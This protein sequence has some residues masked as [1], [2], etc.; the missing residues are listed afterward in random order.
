MD[1]GGLPRP[2]GI[3]S[4]VQ[5]AVIT[6]RS[7]PTFTAFS[8]PHQTGRSVSW[9]TSLTTK[10]FPYF[11]F[12]RRFGSSGDARAVRIL[13]DPTASSL[14]LLPLV[15]PAALDVARS[16]CDPAL[17]EYF[18]SAVTCRVRRRLSSAHLL[19]AKQSGFYQS[20]PECRVAC[21]WR[22]GQPDIRQSCHHAMSIFGRRRPPYWMEREYRS[23]VRRSTSFC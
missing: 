12:S 1:C 6:V 15:R 3:T 18:R 10:R 14:P 8:T 5:R 21:K 2:A 9:L 4:R 13:L 16:I 20:A 17:P 23:I 7:G 11:R 19:W 22:R